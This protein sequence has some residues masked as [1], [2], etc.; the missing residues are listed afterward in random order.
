MRK[1]G[2]IIPEV[3]RVLPELRPNGAI[4]FVMPTHCPECSQPVFKPEDEA[5]TRC[6]NLECPAIVR[7]AIVRDAPRGAERAQ[8]QRPPRRAASAR[9]SSIPPN[10]G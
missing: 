3:V 9:T 10:A 4:R 6:I 1:A 7:G 8:R 5:A 2:E